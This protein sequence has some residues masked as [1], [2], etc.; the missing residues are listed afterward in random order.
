MLHS[1]SDHPCE[2]MPC[3]NSGTCEE[4]GTGD[5]RCTC[6][7]EYV[8]TNCEIRRSIFENIGKFC[9]EEVGELS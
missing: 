6:P 8:G 3:V 1:L 9:P 7:Q 4:I 5:Y 2:L